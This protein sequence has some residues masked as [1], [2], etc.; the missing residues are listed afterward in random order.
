MK[1]ILLLALLLIGTSWLAQAQ[2]VNEKVK[3]E[4]NGTWYA[5]TI[6]KVNDAEKQYFVKYDEWDDGWNEW[7]T[8]ERLKDF[9]KEESNA[10]LTKFKVGDKVEVEYG[11]IPEPATIIEVGDNK[12]QIEYEKKSFG[13]K[14]VTEKQIKKL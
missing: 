1:K 4:H 14:W 13:T 6:L 12:Y 2:K 11:M 9:G 5:G 10:P 3:I 7:V 8:V